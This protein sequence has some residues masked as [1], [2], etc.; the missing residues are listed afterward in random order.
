MHNGINHRWW[1]EVQAL[2]QLV[3]GHNKYLATP[4]WNFPDVR[5]VA[6]STHH[7][8][9]S[10]AIDATAAP[11]ISLFPI[12]EPMAAITRATLHC[13]NISYIVICPKYLLLSVTTLVENKI[14]VYTNRK[15]DKNSC[16]AV[17]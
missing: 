5:Y 6:R 1:V 13:Q 17:G 9:W 10:R 11:T 16:L 14:T 15:N 12:K 4:I 8:L 3:S 2:I 7:M